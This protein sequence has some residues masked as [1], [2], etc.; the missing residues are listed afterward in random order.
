MASALAVALLGAPALAFAQAASAHPAPPSAAARATSEA[1]TGDDSDEV[2]V[3]GKRAPR[4]R[5]AVVG[6]I[7][8]EL[9]LG[10]ADIASYGV[11]SVTELLQEL[12]PETRSDRGR[13]GEGP[14]VLLNG[15]R[16]SGFNEIA[17][18]PTEAIQRVDILPEEVSLKYGYSANQRVVNI[19]LRRRFRALTAE[20]QGGGPTEG[21]QVS[22]QAQGDLLH[23]LHDDRLNLDLKASA[24]SNLLESERDLVSEV[25]TPTGVLQPDAGIDLGSFRTLLPQTRS[26]SANAVYARTLPWAISGTGNATLGA[27]SSDSL[28][29]LADV[30]LDVPAGSPFAPGGQAAAVDRYAQGLGPLRQSTDG[31]TAHLGSTLNK[32]AG[33]W[34]LSLTDAYDHADTTTLTQTG[35]DPTALQAAVSA[36]ALDPFGALPAG[37]VRLPDTRAE[38]VTDGANVQFLGNGPLLNVP[39]GQLYASVKLGDTQSW[40]ASDSRVLGA[41]RALDLSR[42]DVNAQLNLDLPL[43]GRDFHHLRWLGDLS[44]NVNAAVDQLSDFGALR[45]YGYGVNWTPRDGL[46]LIVSQTHDQAAPSQAQLGAPTVF[47]PGLRVFDYVTGR[48]VDVI[49]VTGGAQGLVADDRTVTKLGL[50]W[51]PLASQQ[52]TLSAD[53]VR[54]RIDNPISTFPA[55]TAQIQAAFPDRFVRDASGE[56]V[57]ADERPVNFSRTDR[58]ELRWGFDYSRP[59]GPQPQRR[60]G[61]GRGRGGGGGPPGEGGGGRRGGGTGGG[62]RGGGGRGGFGGGLRAPGGRLQFAVYHTVLFTDRAVVRPGGPV[63]DYLNG[64]PIGSAGGAPQQEVEAQ[65]GLTWKGWGA[66]ASFDWKSATTVSGAGGGALGDLDFSD[67]ATVNLRLFGN[68]GQM[69]DLVLKHRW[70][71]GVRVTASATNLF[72]DRITVRDAAGA[73]PVIYQPAYL[74]PAGRTFRISVRKLFF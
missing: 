15:R 5:G 39:A 25:A 59:I 50:T 65:A 40:L 55:I 68:L 72:D 49:G 18:I 54:S 23:I 1:D 52:L 67:L 28:Q 21:G 56:L 73:T 66:R 3:T 22:G 44:V 30:S 46:S 64:S 35:A 14:V 38:Q 6:D 26:V 41:D 2:V 71:R 62:A 70:L 32:D 53:Y 8:P 31:W 47:T 29:G 10:P 63:L 69:P 61:G 37:L 24:S 20:G 7:K 33:D 58:S 11:S 4:Q 36:G 42:N 9:Q 74:D 57:Q 45:T 43:L 19:V 48:T 60:F 13:G 27:T 17:N 16:I 51:K 12:S 34:R